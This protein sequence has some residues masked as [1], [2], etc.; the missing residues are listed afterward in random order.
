MN[1]KRVEVLG[2]NEIEGV[3]VVGIEKGSGV[4][5]GGIKEGDIIKKF[6]NYK[7]VKFLD[8]VGYL[9]FKWFNDVVD[10]IVFR[11]GN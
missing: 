10:V 3:Y 2:I 7:I 4:D 8:L 9:G 6:D 11:N 1:L 5:K